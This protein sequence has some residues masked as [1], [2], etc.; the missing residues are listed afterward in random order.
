MLF[1]SKIKNKKL[2]PRDAKA[3]LA[4]EIVKLYHGEK[5]AV[6]AQKEFD[7]VFKEKKLPTKIPEVKISQKSLN[8][9]DLL[10]KTKLASSKSEAKRLILQGGVKIGGIIQKDWGEM[11]K[12]KKG[13][14]I[15]VGKRRFAKI[16]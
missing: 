10:T 16:I 13:Q 6:D 4:K 3:R 15:Q 7:S 5:A 14:I 1:R 2:N 8:V 9:L 11:V 12:I